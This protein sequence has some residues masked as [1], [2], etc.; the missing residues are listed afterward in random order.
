MASRRGRCSASV[1]TTCSRSARSGAVHR[2]CLDGGTE[3]RGQDFYDGT[4]GVREYLRW[5]VAPWYQGDAIAG[6]VIHSENITAQVETT[7]QLA[8]RERM[9]RDLFER[10]PFGL[11]VADSTGRWLDANPA[12]LALIGYTAAEAIGLT[13]AQLTPRRYDA[14]DARQLDQ[15]QQQG[16]YGPYEKELVCKDGRLVPVRMNGF[17]VDREGTSYLWF[18]IEDLTS[19][20]ALEARLEE[21]QI[22]AI[23]ASKLAMMGELACTG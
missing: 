14:D 17:R 5:K 7:R 13:Y 23:H 4:N 20:R 2:R 1:T 16:R 19:Q 10:S 12:L 15:L 9:I 22:G 6:L 8:E 11:N 3:Q 18:L 21:A